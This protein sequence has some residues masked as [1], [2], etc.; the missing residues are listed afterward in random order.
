M[1]L[2]YRKTIIAAFIVLAGLSGYYVTKLKFSF[3]FEQ[4]FPVGDPDL[5]FYNN[6]KKDF[7]SD[8]NFLLIA[9]KNNPSVF[10]SVF[11]NKFHEFGLEVRELPFVIKSQSLTQLKYPVKT[12]FGIS[13]I[14]FIHIDEP[15]KYETDKK[16]ILSDERFVYNLIDSTGTSLVIA[17]KTTENIGLD[18]S[19]VLMDALDSLKAKYGFEATHTLGRANFQRDLVDF[20]KKEMLLAFI[21]SI[22]LVT[23]FMVLIY[24]KPIGILISLGSI[25]L[26]LLLFMGL[27]GFIG[28]ELNAISALFPVV[29]LIV[30]SS[31]VIHIFS[32]YVDE[33]SMGKEK[34]E[35][36][37]ITIKEIGL[38][39]FLTSATT[40]IGF[41]SLLASKLKTI[42]HF[43][44][45]AAIGVLVAYVTVLFFTT[46]LLSLFDKNQ[47]IN[48][49][50]Y[51]SKWTKHLDRIYIVNITQR[52]RIFMAAI[53]FCFIFIL[54][55]SK[56]TTNY[57][58]EDNLPVGE[59]I[60][61][62]FKFYEK[63]YAGFRPLE[64]AIFVQDTMRVDDYS[65]VKEIDKLEQK[66]KSSGVIKST[67]SLATFYRS[68]NRM[69]NANVDS[70]YLFPNTE[71]EFIESRRLLERITGDDATILVSKDKAKT[72][73]SS[74][75][76]DIGTE[77]IKKLG[78]DLDTWVDN[79]IDTNIISVKRTG[80]GLI[81]DKNSEY[82]T[83]SLLKGLG[84]S[85]IIISLMMGLMFKSLRMVI[86][87]LI[88]NLLPLLFAAA[89]L[90]Y[91]SIELEAGVSIMFAIVFG[92]AVDDSIHFLGRYKLCLNEGLSKEAA[93][94]KTLHD[95]GKA[96]IFTTIILF[97]GFFSMFFSVYP[98]TFTV[99]LLISI[100]LVGALICDLY[101]L[102]ALIL[103]FTK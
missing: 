96:I 99:G 16:N 44:I 100:T 84:F 30:G 80:T 55:I 87:A 18:D 7:E 51:A 52:Q 34:L 61:N 19:R 24:R 35:A 4:F 12:P 11:L 17:A 28:A 68:I 74:R 22:I 63:H 97:F 45:Y 49:T 98:P 36:M 43:G 46:S 94:R 86:I 15:D 89:M 66:I 33:L 60:T 42:Q 78:R 29:M 101:L 65:V 95:T 31:D 25:A 6:F 93:I 64:F 91:F 75:I 21:S 3:Q 56:I 53:G 50:K 79:N 13:A 38:A 39:T 77:N 37:T 92:I 85:I 41:A 23:F 76:S 10:D 40:A 2:N 1:F 27:L 102:P 88:P 59:P 72:R 83:N 90:G 48:E 14:P 54:G 67:L 62:D 103:R 58:I 8:D 73:I 70:A 69:N 20:Q 57:N 5:E 9:V 47:I 82:V 32:K 81:L 71:E 26:G